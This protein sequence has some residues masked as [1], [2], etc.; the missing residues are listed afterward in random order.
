MSEQRLIDVDA[1]RIDKR[2]QQGCLPPGTRLCAF[3]FDEI[4]G[5]SNEH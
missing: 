4:G 2:V 1:L 3:E 5:G